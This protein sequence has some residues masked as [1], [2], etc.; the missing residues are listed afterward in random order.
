MKKLLACVLA[1]ALAMTVLAGCG[2]QKAELA[3]H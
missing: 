2:S 1:I 3:C